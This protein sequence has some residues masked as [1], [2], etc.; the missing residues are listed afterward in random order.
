MFVTGVFLVAYGNLGSLLV[1][2][3]TPPGWW[4][5]VPLEILLGCLALLWGWSSHL[6]ASQG[7]DQTQL[8]FG[9][10][11]CKQKRSILQ[12]RVQFWASSVRF[13]ASREADANPAVGNGT[14][15]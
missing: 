13:G 5:N 12:R 14:S 7:L 6:S 4:P 10:N 9:R 2:S 11:A 8:V 15:Q 1:G 3:A